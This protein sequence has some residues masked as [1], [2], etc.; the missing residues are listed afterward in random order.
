LFIIRNRV[1][2]PE[3]DFGPM[4]EDGRRNKEWYEKI[5]INVSIHKNEIYCCLEYNGRYDW[6]KKKKNEYQLKLP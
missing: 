6:Q 3:L 5:A 1:G 4:P 2:R